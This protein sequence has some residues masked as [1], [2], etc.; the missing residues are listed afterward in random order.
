MTRDE[1]WMREAL[2]LAGEAAA[3]GE[4]PVGAVVVKDGTVVGRGRNRRETEKNALCHAELE[5]I[6]EA[7]RALGGWRLWQCELFV[8]LE[9]CPMCAGAIINA[10]IPRV[11]FGA[12]DKKAG[13][14]G[15]VVNLFELPYNHRPELVSGVLEQECAALLTSF[16]QRLRNQKQGG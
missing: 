13:S 6:G 7:C 11:V 1:E 5:A 16:F 9:P 12:K 4:V 10:R 15:S 3:L 8:T 14:C 2:A